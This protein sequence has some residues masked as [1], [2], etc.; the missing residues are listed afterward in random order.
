MSC[1]L[2]GARTKG[3]K[4]LAWVNDLLRLREK[5]PIDMNLPCHQGQSLGLRTKFGWASVDPP[6]I[7]G[8]CPGAPWLGLPRYWK[9]LEDRCK[10]GGGM[11]ESQI[12]SLWP[13]HLRNRRLWQG[14][15]TWHGVKKLSSTLERTT[16]FCQSRLSLVT[17]RLTTLSSY[18]KKMSSKAQLQPTIQPTI[19]WAPQYLMR[20][21]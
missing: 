16:M 13:Y 20:L 21:A 18:S 17:A 7:S 9:L 10:Y 12:W 4:F 15:N 14:G 6:I 3:F 19:H 2:S 5:I 11:E 1:Y 8:L